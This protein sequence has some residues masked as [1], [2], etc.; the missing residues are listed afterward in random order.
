MKEKEE[1][2]KRLEERARR[3]KEEMENDIEQARL[4]HQK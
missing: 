4:L 3:E 1:Y 2:E